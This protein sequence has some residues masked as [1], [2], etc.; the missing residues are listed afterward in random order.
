MFRGVHNDQKTLADITRVGLPLIVSSRPVDSSI[1][2]RLASY[3]RVEGLVYTRPFPHFALFRVLHC[4][5]T[6]HSIN[7]AF[8]CPWDRGGLLIKVS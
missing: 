8:L 2:M 6:I 5:R 1:C 3:K 7:F 4:N